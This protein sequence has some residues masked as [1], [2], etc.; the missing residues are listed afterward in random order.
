MTPYAK[1]MSSPKPITRSI[2]VA[3]FLVLTAIGIFVWW[4]TLA[5]LFGLALRDEQYT[6]ILLIVPISTVLIVLDWQAPKSPSPRSLSMGFGLLIFAALIIGTAGSTPMSSDASLSV[7]VFAFVLWCAGAF[8]GCFG[9]DA[10][11]CSLFPICF[12]LW[13]VPFPPA[14]LNATVMVLQRGSAVAAHL[15][16]LVAGIPVGQRGTLLYLPGITLEVAPECSSMRSS[17]MLIV[18]TMVAGQLLLR[19][20]WRKTALVAAAIPLSIAKNGLRIFVLGAIAIRFDPNIFDSRLHRQGGIIFFLIA[21]AGIVT[22][23]WLLRRGEEKS[24]GRQLKSHG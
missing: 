21:L 2:Q 18:T 19:S 23:L 20:F 9:Q 17:M 13:L 22:L 5:S 11:R 15:F 16:F 4:K 10:F 12:L 24:Y 8:L 14:L 1:E 6:H 7:S 3:A